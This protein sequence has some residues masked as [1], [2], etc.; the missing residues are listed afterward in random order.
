M[1]LQNVTEKF[2]FIRLLV[3]VIDPFKLNSIISTKQELEIGNI[4][5]NSKQYPYF[6]NALEQAIKFPNNEFKIIIYCTD[7]M[8]KEKINDTLKKTSNKLKSQGITNLKFNYFTFDDK[9][10]D[11]LLPNKIDEIKWRAIDYF[12]KQNKNVGLFDFDYIPYHNNERIT[13]V[14][15][16]HGICLFTKFNI[17]AIEA[18]IPSIMC[19]TSK[20]KH[21]LID[22]IENVTNYENARFAIS[23]IISACKYP[24]ISEFFLS[25]SGLKKDC[26]HLSGYTWSNRNYTEFDKYGNGIRFIE[27]TN[28]QHIINELLKPLSIENCIEKNKPS[29]NTELTN[30]A[31]GPSNQF[32]KK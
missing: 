4:I 26:K 2:D 3:W 23:S 20:M 7:Q 12:L 21:Y 22:D 8:H 9:K 18:F 25:I 17:K 30:E 32:T 5:L 28:T 11:I 24:N 13:S 1:D 14:F 10:K 15:E 6:N 19:F 27:N 31:S 29:D 16:K